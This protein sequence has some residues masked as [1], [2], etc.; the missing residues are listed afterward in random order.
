MLQYRMVPIVN[1]CDMDL[2][3]IGAI[4]AE[5]SDVRLAGGCIGAVVTANVLRRRAERI[6]C[7][8]MIDTRGS[9]TSKR[10][11]I[12]KINIDLIKTS[13]DRMESSSDILRMSDDA[14]NSNQ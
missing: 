1:K 5:A 7:K 6:S 14:H 4:L 13:S 3:L 2:L 12:R 11:Q 8:A 10:I 9:A